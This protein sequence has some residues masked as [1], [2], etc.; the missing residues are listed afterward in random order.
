[1]AAFHI[2][3]TVVPRVVLAETKLIKTLAENCKTSGANLCMKSHSNTLPILS[4][5]RHGLTGETRRLVGN[6]SSSTVRYIGQ[7]AQH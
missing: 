5:E 3:K 2:E 1:M 4:F 6:M 7:A